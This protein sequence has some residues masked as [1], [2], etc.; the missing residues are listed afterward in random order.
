VDDTP[1]GAPVLDHSAYQTLAEEI[2]GEMARQMFD[3]FIGETENRLK[4][5]R[6]VS[7]AK[8]PGLIEREAHSLKGAAATFGFCQLSA[9]ARTLELGAAN[10]SAGDCGALVGQ[11]EPAF[12][13][14]CRQFAATN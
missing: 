10:I 6:Q 12:A 3:I 8:D 9:L 11:I 2:G 5:L 1:G 14:A 13:S 4:V 7:C